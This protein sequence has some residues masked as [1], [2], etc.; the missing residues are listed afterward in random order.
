MTVQILGGYRLTRK[1]GEGLRAEVFLGHPAAIALEAGSDP[2]I[3]PRTAVAIKVFRDAVSPSS[4]YR[5]IEA[6]SR[7]AGEHT[8]E[9]LDLAEGPHGKPILIL[10]RLARLTASD[11]LTRR[12]SLRPGEVVTLLAPVV[13][14]V[15][16][17]H[18]AGVAHGSIRTTA[19]QFTHSGA[20]V[21]S[22]FGSSTLFQRDSPVAR[23]ETV[24]QVQSDLDA[25]AR[26]VIR[27]LREVQDDATGE[28]RQWV[29]RSG[30]VRTETLDHLEERLFALAEP[31]AI[32]IDADLDVDHRIPD[33]TTAPP[34]LPRTGSIRL[35]M[36]DE[37]RPPERPSAGIGRPI[38]VP[39]F[40][41]ARGVL[42]ERFAQVWAGSP[43]SADVIKLIA[44]VRGSLSRVR[45]RV[46][47]FSG[48]VAAALIIALIVA[49]PHAT[50][51][52]FETRGVPESSPSASNDSMTVPTGAGAIGGD[53]PAAAVVALLSA[54]E[55][56][57]HL[58]SVLCLDAVL[59]SGSAALGHDQGVV[60]AI[61]SG[62]ELPPPIT[63][64][65]AD[66]SVTERL[67]DSALVRTAN[68]PD[69]GAVL[70]V[71]T[72]AGWRIRSYLPG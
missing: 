65:D 46:W 20:P 26:L 53:D 21:L 63:V 49:S 12:Q 72:S 45:R 47:I 30:S 55:N 33:Y 41:G 23:L 3:D 22:Q 39:R 59:Q 66:V 34:T 16:R 25:L 40:V 71:R 28:L 54:R 38:G 52:A 14:T 8:V 43:G 15:A 29:E 1:L 7:V 5:E 37:A 67:G 51:A 57:I 13:A 10:G 44:R 70:I 11:L 17:M 35:E 32:G 19:I 68:A 48:L 42:V 27:V 50:E 18:R 24:E 69:F 2:P 56:C 62:G 36:D 64:G 4:V 31:V 9:L 60:R 58:N 61:Q 6:L